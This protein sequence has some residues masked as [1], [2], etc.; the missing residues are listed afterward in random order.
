[1]EKKSHNRY[2]P[3]FNRTLTLDLHWTK[4][5]MRYFTFSS[6]TIL[7]GFLFH[8]CD[9]CHNLDCPSNYDGQFR[10]VSAID[11]KDLVFGPN[12]IYDKDQIKFYSIKG[13]DTSYFGY[14]T[15][16]YETLGPDSV[17]E[18]RFFPK[19]EIAYMRLSNTDVDTL[20]ISYTTLQTKC[21]DITEISNFRYNNSVDF[22]GSKGTLEIKK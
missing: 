12:K 5:F 21:C 22:P 10:I 1:L 6:L 18:V 11:G 3:T 20:N 7:S 13:A 8:S 19:N 15:T 16:K 4:Y 14:Y 2:L 9:R 17:L